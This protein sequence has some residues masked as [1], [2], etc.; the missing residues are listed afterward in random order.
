MTDENDDW[1]IALSVTLDCHVQGMEKLLH[2]GI[3]LNI[4]GMQQYYRSVR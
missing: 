4:R 3:H 1:I 2:Y